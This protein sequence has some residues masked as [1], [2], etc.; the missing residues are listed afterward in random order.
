MN[1]PVLNWISKSQDFSEIR[2]VVEV[3]LLELSRMI[4]ALVVVPLD[5]RVDRGDVVDV[6]AVCSRVSE[7]K[8]VVLTYQTCFAE[9]EL[10]F[11]MQLLFV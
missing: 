10:C 4:R 5:A 2:L 7:V 9:P 8:G 3:G 6:D 1:K 11:V